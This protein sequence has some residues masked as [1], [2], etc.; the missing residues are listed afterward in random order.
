MFEYVLNMFIYI[1]LSC[2][3][4]VTN[5]ISSQ[6]LHYTRDKSSNCYGV[7][8]KQKSVSLIYKLQTYKWK[9]HQIHKG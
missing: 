7:N 6:D 9:I 8:Q 1:F 2:F 3:D 5:W 4:N